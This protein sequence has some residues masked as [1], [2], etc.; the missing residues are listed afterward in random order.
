MKSIVLK[1]RTQVS[2][3]DGKYNLYGRSNP[4]PVGIRLVLVLKCL[5]GK[6]VLNQNVE[7]QTIG[8][9]LV[10]DSDLAEDRSIDILFR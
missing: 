8:D 10:L 3:I 6:R 9:S 2:I 7:L 5:A 1:Y 4:A